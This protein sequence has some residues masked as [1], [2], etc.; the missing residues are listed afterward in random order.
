M[1]S[2]SNEPNSQ[3]CIQ[4]KQQSAD[5]WAKLKKWAKLLRTKD[6]DQF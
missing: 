2:S 4:L 6:V 5:I 1:K 3:F